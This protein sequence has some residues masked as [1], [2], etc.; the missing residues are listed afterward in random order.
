M[1]LAGL[2]GGQDQYD[3]LYLGTFDRTSHSVSGDI[4]ILDEKTIYIQDF[5]HDGQAPDVY[6]WADGVI[7][8]YITRSPLIGQIM[9]WTCCDKKYKL[10]ASCI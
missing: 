4:F 7:I 6:F 2:G 5:S 8:P 3:P 9:T 1:A 10:K